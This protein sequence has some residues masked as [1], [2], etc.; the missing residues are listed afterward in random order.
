MLRASDDACATGV[1]Y[2]D[3]RESRE[4][5]WQRRHLVDP[6][7][8]NMFLENFGTKRQYATITLPPN[9]PL[10]PCSYHWAEQGTV[11]EGDWLPG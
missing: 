8:L 3:R 7:C 5:L 9:L 1:H 11:G 10:L 2:R 4:D 6:T